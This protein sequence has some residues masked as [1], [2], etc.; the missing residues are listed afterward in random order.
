M[1]LQW[2]LAAVIVSDLNDCG[3]DVQHSLLELFEQ[4]S[5]AA[6]VD[7]HLTREGDLDLTVEHLLPPQHQDLCRL[8][9]LPQE[10]VQG[11]D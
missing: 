9:R 2:P 8:A 1:P 7:I 4:K 10:T 5:L 11:R 6:W 3:Q